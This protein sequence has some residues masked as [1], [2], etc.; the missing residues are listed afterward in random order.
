MK[1]RTFRVILRLL[2]GSKAWVDA[3]LMRFMKLRA[4]SVSESVAEAAATVKGLGAV[5]VLWRNWRSV[6]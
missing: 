2:V 6:T 1:K 4:A 5:E 3:D